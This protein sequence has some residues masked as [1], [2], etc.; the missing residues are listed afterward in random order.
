MA[1]WEDLPELEDAP[2]TPEERAPWEDLPEVEAPPKPNNLVKLMSF[3]RGEANPYA[4]AGAKRVTFDPDEAQAAQAQSQQ[5][6]DT[7]RAYDKEKT[8]K[9]ALSFVS[10]GGP[11]VDELA[12]AQVAAKSG[13]RTLTEPGYAVDPLT[14]YRRGRDSARTEVDQATRDASPTVNLPL[15]GETPVLPLAGAVVSTLPVPGAATLAERLAAGGFMGGLGALSGSRADLTRGDPKQVRRALVD[16]AL[17]TGTGIAAA[18][19]A[20]AP[21]ALG[22]FGGEVM[23]RAR[24]AQQAKSAEAAAKQTA[25]A[26]AASGQ[27]GTA[28]RREVE[29]AL[30]MLRNPDDFAPEVVAAARKSLARPEVQEELARQM[31]NVADELP[32]AAARKATTREEFVRMATEESGRAANDAS[33]RL[34]SPY[35]NVLGPRAV[36]GAYRTATAVGDAAIGGATKGWLPSSPVSVTMMMNMAKDPAMR[37]AVGGS[38]QK[39]AS[40]LGNSGAAG[41]AGASRAVQ[42]ASDISEDDKKAISAFVDGG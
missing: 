4:P 34:A 1:S 29:L 7:Q 28:F 39:W 26:R 27:A 38:L 5:F 35:A 16:T 19:V 6:A 2:A 12:G 15:L 13:A 32:A 18:G 14:S 25:A 11:L 21:R 9:G 37:F 23:D 10:G 31:G 8:L 24:L 40:P 30:D 17:G 42:S 20:E 41:A 3:L 36:R 33:E 22:K